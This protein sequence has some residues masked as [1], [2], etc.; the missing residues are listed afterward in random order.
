MAMQS[1]L[2]NALE[3]RRNAPSQHDRRVERRI[4]PD[5]V[6]ER[7]PAIALRER[8]SALERDDS[9]SNRHPALSFCLSMIFSEN[10]CPL[11]R[12]MLQA[13]MPRSALRSEKDASNIDAPAAV[14]HRPQPSMPRHGSLPLAVLSA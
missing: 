14:R 1:W 7:G 6:A 9:S 12:I 2:W 10:R 11:F 13:P 3:S 4:K 5:A 8:N